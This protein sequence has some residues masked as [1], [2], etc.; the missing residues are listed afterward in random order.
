MGYNIGNNN[1]EPRSKTR[2]KIEKEIIDI[3]V[4]TNAMNEQRVLQIQ[5][6][7]GRF[8]FPEFSLSGYYGGFAIGLTDGDQVQFLPSPDQ[9]TA[10]PSRLINVRTSDYEGHVVALDD[11]PNNLKT[12]FSQ[13]QNGTTSIK[14]KSFIPGDQIRLFLVP[15]DNKNPDFRS[16]RLIEQLKETSQRATPDCIFT[17]NDGGAA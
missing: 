8:E 3:Y 16:T 7:E 10:H 4:E 12:L 1:Q 13:E 17:E 9:G 6:P 11:I 5:T 14:A 2:P 15:F